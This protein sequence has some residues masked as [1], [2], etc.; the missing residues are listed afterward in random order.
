RPNA[1]TRNS[2]I[3]ERLERFAAG[4]SRVRLVSNLGTEAY[5]GLFLFGDAAG[6]ADTLRID[7]ESFFA[8]I[9]SVTEFHCGSGALVGHHAA[10]A[11]ADSRRQSV[12]C[13]KVLIHESESEQFSWWW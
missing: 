5:F 1:D 4:R 2:E 6:I 10:A 11:E 3:V 9:D 8:G 12:I 7:G 13:R